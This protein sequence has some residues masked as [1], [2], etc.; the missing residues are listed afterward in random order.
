VPRFVTDDDASLHVEIAGAGGAP[1]VVLVHG[2]AGP[3]T[4][5]WH[6]TGAIDRLVAAG[7][8]VVAYDARGH[9]ESDA[10]HD[11]ARYGDD[12]LV[13]DLVAVTDRFA[14]EQAV[15]AGY[16]MGAATILLALSRGWEVAGAVIGGA[17][18]AVLA[19]TETDE[20]VRNA[21]VAVLEGDEAP[22]DTMQLWLGFLDSIG[23]DRAALAALLRGHQPVVHD[24]PRITVPVVVAAGVDDSTAAPLADL[25]AR[26][27]RGRALHLPGDHVAALAAPAFTDAIVDLAT[28]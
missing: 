20:R 23:A 15:V 21:A 2:L 13:A 27:P 9:G 16:S 3:V 6:A 7:L 26:L 17:P 10:P 11:A 14:D 25:T 22:D 28:A 8:R 18:T 24:W 12:R 19:W 5:S 4:L 1:T